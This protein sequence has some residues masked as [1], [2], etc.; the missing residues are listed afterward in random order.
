MV[1]QERNWSSKTKPL[2]RPGTGVELKTTSAG[3]PGLVGTRDIA[4]PKGYRVY[5]TT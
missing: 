3:A 1:D 2:V 5:D 4:S